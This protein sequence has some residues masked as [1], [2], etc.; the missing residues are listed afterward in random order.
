M[1]TRSLLRYCLWMLVGLFAG[2]LQVTAQSASPGTLTSTDYKSVNLLFIVDQSGSMGGPPF[3]GEPIYAP[4]GNDEL[5]LRFAGPQ[6]ALSLITD[7]LDTSLDIT[8]PQIQ[9]ALLTFGS[10]PRPILDWTLIQPDSPLWPTRFANI[11]QRLSSEDWPGR[12]LGST[13]ILDSYEFALSY[14]PAPRTLFPTRNLIILLTDGA[15]CVE[16]DPAFQETTNDGRIVFN[17]ATQNRLNAM[18]GHLDNLRQLVAQNF[19]DSGFELYIIGLDPDPATVSPDRRIFAFWDDLLPDWQAVMCGST[20]CPPNRIQ[21]AFN[22]NEIAGHIRTILTNVFADLALNINTVASLS[23]TPVGQSFFVPP[24]QQVMRLDLYK[25]DAAEM[26][27]ITV[28]NDRLGMLNASND[29]GDSSPV[30][31]LEFKPVEPGTYTLQFNASRIVDYLVQTIPAGLQL[32][33]I[34]DGEIFSQLPLVTELVRGDGT[35]LEDT[36]GD[37]LNDPYPLAVTVNIYDR[38]LID[39]TASLPPPITSIT[40]RRDLSAPDRYRFTGSWVPT[41]EGDYQIK[42]TA[43]YRDPSGNTQ[44]L[45]ADQTLQDSLSIAGAA[46]N[47]EGLQ[48]GITPLSQRQD[49]VFNGSAAISGKSSGLPINSGGLSL[50][51]LLSQI[52]ADGTRLALAPLLLP[53]AVADPSTG[54]VEAQF[55]IPQPGNYEAQLEVG[56]QDTDGSFQRLELPSPI[57]FLEVRPLRLLQWEINQPAESSMEAQRL[58]FQ[59]F[60]LDLSTSVNLQLVLRD[61][62]TGAPVSL[63]SVT[64]GV[65]QMPAAT[66]NGQPSGVTLNEAPEGVYTAQFTDLGMGDFEIAVG[67]A[68]ALPNLVGDYVWGTPFASH[69]LRR[70]PSVTLI[71]TVISLVAGLVLTGV[72]A[73]VLWKREEAL[74]EHPLAGN[75]T[76]WLRPVG[77]TNTNTISLDKPVDLGRVTRNLQKFNKSEL[78]KPFEMLEVQSRTEGDSQKGIAFVTY[79]TINGKN[80]TVNKPLLPGREIKI[81]TYTDE[82]GTYECIIIKDAQDIIA[83]AGSNSLMSSLRNPETR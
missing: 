26:G 30:R 31:T 10:E 36:D 25:R 37:A 7:L 1:G 17:C 13:D 73:Y 6:Y 19:P 57:A 39:T 38:R 80:L 32:E 23:T 9:M 74:R 40:L 44:S 67:S 61:T 14:F 34:P 28:S 2:T 27:S 71:V 52:Q 59:P 41:I 78:P 66:L 18:R 48:G 45:V 51:V 82:G 68:T 72:I 69:V 83:V 4:A 42:V 29:T 54:R 60:E 58:S 35:L 63:N 75:L 70:D 49:Q 46:I 15:P 76:F 55:P 81:G 43:S 5:G 77:E 20:T 79:A 53:N 21:R 33:P 64:G 12:N 22:A 62:L 24:Y 65:E 50:R 56:I 16:D 8:K 3:G 47:W 11:N